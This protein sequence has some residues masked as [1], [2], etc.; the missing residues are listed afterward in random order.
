MRLIKVVPGEKHGKK[1]FF[2]LIKKHKNYC[3]C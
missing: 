3:V 1:A 2:I